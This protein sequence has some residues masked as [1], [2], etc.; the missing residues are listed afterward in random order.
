MN[1]KILSGALA[2][3]MMLGM[4]VPA[5]AAVWEPNENDGY[6]SEI[7]VNTQA[8]VM[9]VTVPTQLPISVDA[10]GESVTNVTAQIINKGAA[11]VK[12][13]GAKVVAANDWA[14][15][16]W[17]TDWSKAALGT[18]E[19]AFKVNDK[20]VGTDGV[21]DVS[22]FTAID[23]N[24]GTMDFTYAGR[25]AP[26]DGTGTVSLGNVV[27]TLGWVELATFTVDGSE[28][29]TEA[30]M[31]WAQWVESDYNTSKQVMTL[32]EYIDKFG[33][34]PGTTYTESELRELGATTVEFNEIF[35]TSDG[36]VGKTHLTRVYDNEGNHIS[37]NGFAPGGTIG[38][39]AMLDE[40]NNIQYSDTL[41][42]ETTYT[43]KYCD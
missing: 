13:T 16:S 32:D 22:G 42:A 7:T 28:Y 34:A 36:K 26:Q 39:Y 14:L 38:S 2:T 41:L 4:S 23:G 24:G 29:Q 17:N 19:F 3:A 6:T 10:N 20:A 43:F 27:F 5:M 18:K 33:Y 40:S 21:V 8:T 1:K 37:G 25:I 30:G 31:T 15:K 11:Q 12:V 35:I 9:N